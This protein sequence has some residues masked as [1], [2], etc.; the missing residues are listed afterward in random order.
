M[1]YFKKSK[2]LTFSAY[3]AKERQFMYL[4]LYI[5]VIIYNCKNETIIITR[6]KRQNNTPLVS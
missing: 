2:Y 6:I 1:N 3:K 4:S 5:N